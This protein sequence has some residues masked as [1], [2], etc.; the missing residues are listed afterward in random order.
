MSYSAPPSSNPEL[1]KDVQKLLTALQLGRVNIQ[2]KLW[3]LGMDNS[4]V[5]PRLSQ[6]TH[7]DFIIKVVRP[8]IFHW[9]SGW[10]D[11]PKD[12]NGVT[13]RG[14]TLPTFIDSFDFLY[15]AQGTSGTQEAAQQINTKYPN[16]KK[17]VELSKQLMYKICGSSNA[18]ILYIFYYLITSESRWP[19]AVM[20]EDP[21][22]GYLLAES[23]WTVGTDVYSANKANLDEILVKLGWNGEPKTWALYLAGLGDKTPQVATQILLYR[24]NHITRMTQPGSEMASY[25]DGWLNRLLNDPKSDLLSLIQINED[26]NLNVNNKF[27]F[28]E[29]EKSHLKRKAEIYKK[30]S[31][32]LPD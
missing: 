4:G 18:D 32:Q 9:D 2:N 14:V 3:K 28:S 21:Y 22:L 1:E 17:D 29:A 31:I 5:T 27:I 24:Y 26:F 30:I 6:L 13:M 15:I 8:L 25:K 23:V 12:K 10:A 7:L 19:I 11:H 20:S 16:W